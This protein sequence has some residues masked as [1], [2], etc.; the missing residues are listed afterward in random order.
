MMR[1][2][3]TAALAA[4]LS[5]SAQAAEITVSTGYDGG[6]YHGVFGRNLGRILAEHGHDVTLQ[7]SAGSAEN[8]ERVAA[9]KAQV[10]FAQADAY[11]A[12][13]SD[14]EIIGSLGQECLFVVTSEEG[15]ID[16]EDQL[17]AEGV[18]IAVGRQGSGSALSWDYA[19][20]LE[21]GYAETSTYYQGG[22]LA[23]SKVR[24]GQ[25]D[26]FFFVTTPGNFDHKFF[27]TVNSDGSGLRFIDFN[28]WD[29][30]DDLPNGEPVYEFRDVVVDESGWMDTEVEVPCTDVLVT[31]DGDMDYAALED[32]ATA[33]MTNSN[34][35][36]GK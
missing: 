3:T 13:Q 24:T 33:V 30:N 26:A 27:K 23:L 2:I 35:I 12:L 25:L 34:R 20:Q 4:S 22:N 32:L 29:M 16:D 11:A 14:T 15:S 28:D 6:S 36:Q 1:L 10:G 21:S 17:Q 9:G 5:L 31:A 7:P 19:R 8:L 18:K